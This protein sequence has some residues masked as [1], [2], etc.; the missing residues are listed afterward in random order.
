MSRQINQT[1][2]NWFEHALRRTR[3]Q[4]QRQVVALGALGFFIALILG[5]LYLSQVVS[6]ATMNRH[7]VELLEQ[8]DEL[9]RQNEL[10]RVQIAELRAVPR[11]QAEAERLGFRLAQPGEIEY[12][13][14]KGYNPVREDTV[15][16]V[17]VDKAESPVYDETFTGWLEQQW[18]LF[19]NWLG[20]LL[21]R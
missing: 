2:Q 3:W 13:P 16:P 12:L 5:A 20:D 17:E 1:S 10:L 9:E 11:L 14:I 18:D 6:E 15:A 19:R 4:P 7:L 8:R 21:G